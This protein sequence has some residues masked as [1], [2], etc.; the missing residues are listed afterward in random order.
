MGGIRV[1]VFDLGC[2][3]KEGSSRA[4]GLGRGQ[5]PRSTVPTKEESG[6]SEVP[7]WVKERTPSQG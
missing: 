7:G 6:G 3:G 2:L 1:E 5:G 4:E